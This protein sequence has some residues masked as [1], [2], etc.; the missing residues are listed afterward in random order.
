METKSSMPIKAIDFIVIGIG[1]LSE[2]HSS[3]R[4]FYGRQFLKTAGNNNF[5]RQGKRLLF[6]G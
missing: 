2:E 3:K 1:R 4:F 6:C 5:F